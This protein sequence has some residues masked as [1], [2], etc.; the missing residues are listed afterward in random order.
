[1]IVTHSELVRDIDATLD[2][3]QK[4]LNRLN[5]DADRLKFP[6]L[7]GDDDRLPPAA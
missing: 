3:M 5:G 1:M 7:T 6:D 2:S 4:R